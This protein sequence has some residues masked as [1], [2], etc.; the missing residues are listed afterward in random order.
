M[1]AVTDLSLTTGWLPVVLLVLGAL[2]ALWLLLRRDRSFL[3][4]GL[5]VGLAAAALLTGAAY[6][7]V[8]DVWRPFPDPLPLGVYG[9]TFAGLAGL[10]L[11]VP[12]ARAA[13]RWPPR[14]LTGVAALLVLAA[15]A[16][17]VNLSFG[18]YPTVGTA[19][20]APRG[21]E[22]DLAAVGGDAA[23]TV[24]SLPLA[25][26]WTPPAD[27][28][29]G[30]RISQ[31]TIPG[32][33]SGF[34]ARPGYVYLPPAYFATPRAVLPVLVL[35]AGQPGTTEDWLNGGTLTETVDGWAREHGGL[36]PVVV[37]ADATGGAVENPLCLDSDIA[38]VQTYLAVDVPAWV[39]ATLQ[40]QDAPAQWAIGGLSYGG[41]CALQL[42]VN[43][44]DV[45]PTVLD[46]S[47]QDEP[48][49]G[50]RQQ[51]VAA[52]FGGDDA[53]F[54][55]VNPLDVITRTSLP[56]SEI[57]VV[58]G[59]QDSTYGPQ[60]RTVVAALQA[61]GVAVRPV[62]LPGGHD[63]GV[64]AAGLRTQLDWLGTRLGITA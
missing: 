32:T 61:A 14:V 58:S 50:T 53:K 6:V 11:L 2:G 36:A 51:T 57:T 62:E 45:Y 34:A 39:R 56:G 49:L 20:G 33:T 42:G 8:E 16:S 46:I 15:A 38:N 24:S 10:A 18:A 9:W 23:A 30:G 17:Q 3:R 54:R 55:A 47:G 27:L 31:V 48:T 7:V 12:R 52:A 64:W 4:R 26:S 13:R 29:A 1:S 37:L 25:A 22:I 59:S 41:T 19:L 44:P 60:A 35:L 21:D 28:P 43:R 63:F 40:T 5:P